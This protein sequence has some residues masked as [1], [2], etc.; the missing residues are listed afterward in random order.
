M[1]KFLNLIM[2]GIDRLA[3]WGFYAGAF[4]MLVLPLMISYE[5]VARYFFSRPTAWV[6]DFS[7]YVLLYSTFF[8]A[9]WLL[10][11]KEHISMVFVTNRLHGKA[12]W[13]FE[14]IQSLLGVFA[15]GFMFWSGV[16][17]AWDN[18]TRWILIIRPLA[19]DIP[20]FI[21]IWV[22]PFGELMLSIYFA[23]D[24]FHSLAGL[25]KGSDAAIVQQVGGRG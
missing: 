21:L 1:I 3:D 9:G 10:R 19:I 14:I 20:V 2:R 23:R 18:L 25:L 6:V 24:F 7:E 15:C 11:Q 16:V 5:V 17:S 12:R 13:I 8:A 4:L 22:I